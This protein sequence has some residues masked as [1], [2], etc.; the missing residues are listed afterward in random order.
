MIEENG[1]IIQKVYLDDLILD[2]NNFR[3]VDDERY[4]KIEEKDK[5]AD[6][7]LQLSF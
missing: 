4:V 7:A 6:T 5:Y 2:P 1:N 3:F